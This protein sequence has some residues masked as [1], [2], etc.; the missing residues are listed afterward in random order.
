MRLGLLP[1][2]KITHPEKI[3]RYAQNDRVWFLNSKQ[4]SPVLLKK[5]HRDI[6][7]ISYIAVQTHGTA[8]S[9]SFQLEILQALTI[10]GFLGFVQ[11]LSE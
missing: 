5:P 6:G 1:V 8:V 9:L 3:L 10:I 11:H 4:L 7:T 2:C